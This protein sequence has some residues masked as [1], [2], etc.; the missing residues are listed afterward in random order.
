MVL[1]YFWCSFT[2]FFILTCGIEVLQYYAVCGYYKSKAVIIGE[3]KSTS[4]VLVNARPWQVLQYCCVFFTFICAVLQFSNSPYAYLY[5]LLANGTGF[6]M[7]RQYLNAYL[8]FMEI[9][10]WLGSKMKLTQWSGMDILWYYTI[11]LLT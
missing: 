7:S 11:H 10:E 4:S 5:A 2:I 6:R 3:K 9:L 1:P 8:V